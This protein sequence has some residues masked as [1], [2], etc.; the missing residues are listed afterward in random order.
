MKYVVVAGHGWREER[1]EFDGGHPALAVAEMLAEHHV[2]E[3][4]EDTFKVCIEVVPEHKP[5]VDVKYTDPVE[6]VDAV[7]VDPVDVAIEKNI[8]ED[9]EV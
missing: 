4:D 3:K 5:V 1:F 9:E 8:N 6:V 2:T 7:K